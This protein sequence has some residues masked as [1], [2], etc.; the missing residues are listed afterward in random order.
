MRGAIGAEVLKAEWRAQIE[1][2]LGSGLQVYFLNSHEH[3]HI[4]PKLS[5][6]IDE[7]AEEFH[8][9]YV[10]KLLP[11][12]GFAKDNSARLRN[13]IASGLGQFSSGRV[14]SCHIPCLGLARSGKLDIDY[15]ASR[16]SKLKPGTL[17]E[18]MCHPGYFDPAEITSPSLLQYHDWEKELRL[19]SSPEVKQLLADLN[20]ELIRFSSLYTPA[21]TTPVLP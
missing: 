20:I 8:V 21:S 11:E 6:I 4:L 7:L 12:W 10:R 19:L 17:S 14:R 18:L 9:P 13:F 5:R 1:R 3:L 16:L 15:L 2:V